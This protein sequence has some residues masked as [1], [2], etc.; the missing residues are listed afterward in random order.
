[1]QS[2]K[3]F[4]EYFRLV[5]HAFFELLQLTPACPY[6]FSSPVFKQTERR[7]DGLLE[8]DE[9]GNPRYFVEFQGYRDEVIYWRALQQVALFHGE[10][11]GLNGTPSHVVLLFLDATYDPGPET[12]GLQQHGADTW[13]TRATLSDLLQGIATSSPEI[14]VLRPLAATEAEVA[15]NAGTWLGTLRRAS[16]LA[17]GTR[18]QL[19]GLL[20]QL[21][22]QKLRHMSREEIEQM[23]ELTP[24]EETVVGQELIEQGKQQGLQQGMQQGLQKA[25]REDILELLSI[26]FDVSPAG[27]AARLET[28]TDLDALRQL[29]R[30]AATA[31]TFTAFEHTL[32]ELA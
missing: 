31:A 6:Q 4:H 10:D 3:L 7:L 13:L 18:E 25:V 17:P 5:P 14:N 26:R 27:T 1:M 32:D 9:P 23:V 29:H 20:L 21:V 16:G 2:D 24:L 15:A 12:L 28:I 30:A 22:I 19:A 11:A 8:P